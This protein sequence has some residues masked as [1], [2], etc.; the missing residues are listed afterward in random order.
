MDAHFLRRKGILSPRN[1]LQHPL[2]PM[3][4]SA[5]EG[6]IEL[7][8][9]LTAL[10]H[11]PLWSIG[12]PGKCKVHIMSQQ[13]PRSGEKQLCAPSPET[14]PTRGPWE[15]MNFPWSRARKQVGRTN[16][17]QKQVLLCQMPY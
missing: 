14:S 10:D 3:Q 17:G 5:Q 11:Q 12:I 16:P 9:P 2:W 6:N 13:R 7:W 1:G 15:S 4:R 8:K